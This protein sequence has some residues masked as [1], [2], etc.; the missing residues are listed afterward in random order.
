MASMSNFRKQISSISL[1]AVGRICTKTL[2]PFMIFELIWFCIYKDKKVSASNS[3][4]LYIDLTFIFL[5]ITV[6]DP[7]E[8]ENRI[9]HA[10]L[11]R[12]ARA[13]LQMVTVYLRTYKYV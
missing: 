6:F 4:L 10:F 1:S 13:S 7:D 9:T 3:M 8:M 12:G 5:V 2:S 11:A